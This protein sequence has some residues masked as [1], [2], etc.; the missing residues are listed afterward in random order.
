MIKAINY[1]RKFL[2]NDLILILLM[3]AGKIQKPGCMK[4]LVSRETTCMSTEWE[5]HEDQN[6]L[7][8]LPSVTEVGLPRWGEP[9]EDHCSL[10]LFPDKSRRLFLRWIRSGLHTSL[11][12]LTQSLEGYP[13]CL[14]SLSINGLMLSFHV[15]LWIFINSVVISAYACS[16]DYN[17]WYVVLYFL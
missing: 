4:V 3:R 13:A 15:P 9:F 10:C 12:C 6:S 16:H 14:Q 1:R 11:L 7:T 8:G 2:S 5:T 17:S